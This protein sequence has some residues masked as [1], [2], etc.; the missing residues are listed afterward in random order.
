MSER[1]NCKVCG[2][3]VI[4]PDELEDIGD[5]GLMCPSCIGSLWEDEEIEEHKERYVEKQS[6]KP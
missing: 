6:P 4:N 5:I 1:K 2:K 3:Y